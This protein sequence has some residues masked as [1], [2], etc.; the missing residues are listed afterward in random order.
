[1]AQ[2][3]K[4]SKEQLYADITAHG[5]QLQA[6]FKLDGD[7]V[8]LCK[9][10]FRIENEAHRIATQYCNGDIDEQ[11]Y[12]HERA[13]ILAKV[14]CILNYTVKRIPVLF[15][16]DARGYTLKISDEY[17]RDLTIYRDMGGYGIIAPDLRR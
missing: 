5:E 9:R 13:R 11:V 17:A 6:I 12:E 4:Q 7:P 2:A 16:G 15:N 14:D 3:Q 8:Q 1:M 10:L